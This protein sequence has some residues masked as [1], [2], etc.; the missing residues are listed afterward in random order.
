MSAVQ[1]ILVVLVAFVAGLAAVVDEREFHQPLVACTLMGLVLGHPTEG[2][3]IGG[4]LQLIALGWMNIGAAMAPD[5]AL[6]STIATLIAVESNQSTGEAVA[7]A[8]PLAIAGQ[9][10]TI[11]IR[12]INV[13]F[14]HQA[15]KFAEKGSF[16]GVEWSHWAAFALQGLRVAVPTGI[17]ATVAG[18]PSVTRALNS[19]PDV[20]TGGLAAAGGFI[21]VV[22]Y[23]MVINLM[24]ARRLMPFFFMGF[25]VATFATTAPA[26][27]GANV[28]GITLV[29]LGI[30]GLCL[31]FIYLQLDPEFHDSIQMPQ[32]NGNGNGSS[33]GGGSGGDEL[34][35][36]LDDELV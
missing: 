34:D 13:Y 20:L 6:A 17:V 27:A 11:F 25:I 3:M 28:S 32:G 12:T 29:A 2:I 8:V 1:F 26:A 14:M 24:N 16:R 5:T 33:G 9:L 35:D 30:L 22:G 21:V 10:L 19:L 7:I 31:A 36:D 18:A 4:T 15:D 23:A